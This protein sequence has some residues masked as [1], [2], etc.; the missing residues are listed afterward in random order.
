MSQSEKIAKCDRLEK[1]SFPA[2]K[3]LKKNILAHLLGW[4]WDPNGTPDAPRGITRRPL[5]RA[6][7]SSTGNTTFQHYRDDCLYCSKICYFIEY[8][9][10]DSP[11]GPA[12]GFPAPSRVCTSQGGRQKAQQRHPPQTNST[13]S[14]CFQVCVPLKQLRINF[15][16]TFFKTDLCWQAYPIPAKAAPGQNSP[17]ANKRNSP[18][19]TSRGCLGPDIRRSSRGSS[20]SCIGIW[21]EWVLDC[22]NSFFVMV[23]WHPSWLD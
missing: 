2:A 5:L 11:D 8:S 12:A 20:S 10:R 7:R 4:L 22:V 23:G 18:S 16:I 1:L 6:Q 3:H 17:F 14:K 9:G 15:W 19:H 13:I 21:N